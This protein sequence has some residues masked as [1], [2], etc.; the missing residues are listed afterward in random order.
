MQIALFGLVLSPRGLAADFEVGIA[1]E[2]VTPPEPIR[3]TG[4]AS[5]QHEASGVEQ[6]LWAKAVA[7]SHQ[8]SPSAVLIT[9]DNCGVCAPIADEVS[10]RLEKKA[11]LSRERLAICSSHTHSGPM[12]RGFAPNIFA[13][14]IPADEQQRIER[15]SDLLT[16]AIERVALAALGDRKPAQLEWNEG[17]VCFAK[18]RRT[19][20]GPIDYALPV[21]CVR[22]PEGKARAIVANYACHCTT[23]GGDFNKIHGDWAG[24]AQE[25]MERSLPGAMAMI[26]IGCGADAN[27]DPRGTLD[28]AKQHGRELAREAT[29]IASNRM[30]RI[31]APPS[32]RL[33]RFPLPFSALPTRSEWQERSAQQGVMGYLARKKLGLLDRGETPPTTLPYTLQVW[34]FGDELAMVFLAGEVVVDYARWLKEKYDAT[35]LWVTAYANDVPCYIPSR[36]ILAEGGYE[37][38]SSLWYYDRPARLAPETEPLIQEKAAAMLPAAFK[39]DPASAENPPA[40][41]AA[42]SQAAMRVGGGLQ[43]ELVASE[44]LVLDPIAIDWDARGRLWVLEMGD[45]PKGLD[46]KWKA[47]GLVKCLEDRD[48]N[49]IPEQATLFLD[50]LS[51]PTGIMCWGSGVFVCSAPDILFAQDTDGDGRADKIEKR[52]TGFST[53]NYNARVNGLSLGLD[54][55]IYGAGGLLGGVIDPGQVDISGRD[56]RFQPRNGDFESATGLSQQ[57]RVR[58]DWGNWFGCDNSVLLW[59]YPF[60]DH[61]ARRNPNVP[62]PTPRVALPADKDPNKLF[63][64][65][66]T[67]ERFNDFDFA[68]R[69]TSACGVAIYRDDWLGPEYYGNAFTCEAV[70]NLV[71]RHLLEPDGATFRSRR[72]SDEQEREFLSS[73][74]NWTRFVQ[75]RTGPD[76]ALWLVDMYRFVIEHPTWI[77]EE[78]QKQL[79]LRAGAD[80]GRIYRLRVPGKPLRATADLTKMET[81]ALAAALDSHNGSERDRVHAALWHRADAADSAPV[82]A[83][84]AREADWP[85]TRVQALCVLDA[86]G[87]LRSEDVSHALRDAHPGVTREAVRLSERFALPLHGLASDPSPSVRFQ[88]ALSTSDASTLSALAL[89]HLDDAWIEAAVLSSASQ[90]AADVFQRVVAAP[91]SPPRARWLERL[92]ASCPDPRPLFTHLKPSPGEKLKSWQCRALAGVAAKH[93]ELSQEMKS[94]L[95]EAERQAKN[96]DVDALK[97]AAAIGAR[98][99][100]LVSFLGTALERRALEEAA[101]RDDADVPRLLLERWPTQPPTTRAHIVSTLLARQS[102]E[103]ALLSAVEAGIVS[104][105]EIPLSDQQRLSKRHAKARELFPS[106]APAA[107]EKRLAPYAAIESRPA[108]ARAGGAVFQRVCATCHAFAGTGFAVGPD[109]APFRSKPAADFLMAMVAPSAAIEPRYVAYETKTRDGRTRAGIISDETSTS[110][111]LIQPGGITESLL[112]SEVERIS[113]LPISLMPEGL[114]Q[115]ITVQEMADLIAWFKTG[116]AP[117]GGATP[118]QTAKARAEFLK[119]GG[120]GLAKVIVSAWNEPYPSWMGRLPLHVCRQAAG[121][122]SLI[123]ESPPAPD[124]LKPEENYELRVPAAMGFISQPAGRFALKVNNSEAVEFEVALLDAT[125]TSLSRAMVVRYD[126]FEASAEDSC[127]LLTISVP[128]RILSAGVPVRFEVTGTSSNSQRWFGVYIP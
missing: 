106:R 19:A 35:R 44:P 116:P 8:G 42:E 74:D 96:G 51:F 26:T 98:S 10:Q 28:L 27:P 41:S 3:L 5:R 64:T 111:T 100:W 127:G 13:A 84:L 63:P 78:R 94:F 80:R 21:L 30:R 110:L 68:N 16:D 102:W 121:A 90:C 34:A 32:C 73:R 11:G 126:V 107:L 88:V 52:H 61:S 49:G 105:A 75:A 128:A 93:P 86:L 20:G 81:S 79:D 87:V 2:D 97:L 24:S 6:R 58:D 114:E 25:E 77:P 123:W 119:A 56:F 112:R 108:N 7:I 124:G 103:T 70:H 62:S 15:Y 76:G 48:G 45:Y 17:Q 38:E 92:V 120:N 69:T 118:E 66:R 113:A 55:W 109:L 14:E 60:P 65:S 36:R 29:G 67:L 33:E 125:W 43:V 12:A 95:G 54:N 72:A 50:N 83:K 23:L 89:A 104:V 37:A 9:V 18:N 47:G 115:A 39:F 57:G 117:F 31:T 1:R 46:G 82:L 4:Y 122:N 59:H 53:K 91:D 22:S 85:A 101:K 99:K 40:R 71:R